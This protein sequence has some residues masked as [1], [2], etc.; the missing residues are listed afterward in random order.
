M[1]IGTANINCEITSGGVK[2]APNVKQIIKNMP[3]NSFNLCFL[4]ILSLINAFTKIGIWNEKPKASI[5][6]RTKFKNFEIS[7]VIFIDSGPTDWKKLNTLGRTNKLQ[8]IKPRKNKIVPNI[9]RENTI[10]LSFLYSPEAIKANAWYKKK[11][12]DTNKAKNPVNLN[13]TRN[14]D[15][16]SIAISSIFD[17]PLIRDT[18]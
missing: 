17:T 7:V 11:G 4:N 14:G 13:G 9:V 8:K 5:S 16:T 3:L 6:V 2:I 15:A 12:I 18:I 10:P 1:Y